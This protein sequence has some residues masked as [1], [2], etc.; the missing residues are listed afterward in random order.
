MTD[1]GRAVGLYIH[2]PFCLRKCGY[3]DFY[4]VPVGEAPPPGMVAS[5]IVKEMQLRA[6]RYGRLAVRTIFFGGGTPSLMPPDD[7]ALVLDAACAAF[8]V[9]RGAEITMEANPGTVTLDSLRGYVRAGVNR[10]SLGAQS[11]DDRL[12]A[13]LGRAHDAEAIFSA[14]EDARAAGIRNLS[15]DVMY[16]LPGQTPGDLSVTLERLLRLNP[17][18]MSCYELTLEPDTPMGRSHPTLPDEDAV[19]EMQSLIINRLSRTG[20]FRYEISNYARPGYI[21]RHNLIYWNREPYLGI[22]PAA[23]SLV[24]ETRFA[25]E[26]DVTCWL[27]RV[28]RGELDCVESETI[29]PGE[30]RFESM[31]LGLRLTDGVDLRAFAQA[32]GST[33]FDVWPGLLEEMRDMGW[34]NCNARRVWLTPRGLMMHNAVCGKL[35]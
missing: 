14:A 34:M 5:A 26:R 32:H 8:E 21:C 23:H 6:A 9:E 35:L 27:N 28:E 24:E 17:E 18:H 13:E 33:P 16:G 10:L 22:G 31:M 3:C 20:L 25:N 19:V 7:I 29:P 30:A 4:S 15:F 12:L 11:A 1:R 2:I